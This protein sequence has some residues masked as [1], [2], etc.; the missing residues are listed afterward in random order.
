M[1]KNKF[2][3]IVKKIDKVSKKLKRN[4]GAPTSK[5]SFKLL[6]NNIGAIC[7]YKIIATTVKSEN[8]KNERTMFFI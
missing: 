4:L 3:Q 7:N 5:I 2:L 1:N 6:L 8:I